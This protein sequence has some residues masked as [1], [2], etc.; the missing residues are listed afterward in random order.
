MMKPVSSG[1]LEGQVEGKLQQTRH[2][3]LRQGMR[4]LG[5]SSPAVEAQ[6]EAISS[7][8]V[9]EALIDCVFDVETWDDLLGNSTKQIG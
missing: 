6:L 3:L 1:R 5:V 2:I 4:R 8:D 7:L 9:L